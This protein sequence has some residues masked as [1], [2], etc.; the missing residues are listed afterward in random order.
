MGRIFYLDFATP[1]LFG[2][3][4]C[5]IRLTYH[6]KH[7]QI[8]L[9]RGE[10]LTCSQHWA[11]FA[12]YIFINVHKNNNNKGLKQKCRKHKIP[13]HN[14]GP[15][16]HA[17]GMVAEQR[18]TSRTRAENKTKMHVGPKGEQKWHIFSKHNGEFSIE[19]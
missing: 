7:I 8:K 19:K 10:I 9:K 2:A 4:V 16:Q 18:K 5:D 1:P 12:V 11:L 15:K 3:V 14:P 17:H 13:L 6:L